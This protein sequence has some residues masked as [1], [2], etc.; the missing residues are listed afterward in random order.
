MTGLSRDNAGH[1]PQG[2]AGTSGTN[3]LYRVVPCPA[4]PASD[5]N[6][7]GTPSNLAPR[8]LNV[9]QAA[10][11][12]SVSFWTMRD[13]VLAGFVPT[14][15]LP[16]LRAREGARQKPSLRRVLI[17]R[18]DLDAFIEAR[19]PATSTWTHGIQRQQTED[20]ER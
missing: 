13:Y 3:P 2:D 9:Q 10:D 20:C 8:L 16:A 5:E 17:D 14:V 19:K 12:L 11:Y 7:K 4:T 18:A 15:Q 1:V 6:R